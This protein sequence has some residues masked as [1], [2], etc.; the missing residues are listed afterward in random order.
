MKNLED[1]VGHWAWD[2]RGKEDMK[3]NLKEWMRAKFATLWKQDLHKEKLEENGLDH[4]KLREYRKYKNEFVMEP[5]LKM[6]QNRNQRCDLTRLRLSAHH[7]RIETGRWVNTPREKR[8][9]K[10]F[11]MQCIQGKE[12]TV[13]G[14][15]EYGRGEFKAWG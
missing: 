15:N 3:K 9:C 13:H 7:L 8:I 6:V 11:G 1:K 4:N 12:S 14:Q 5:Y 10:Y 2:L